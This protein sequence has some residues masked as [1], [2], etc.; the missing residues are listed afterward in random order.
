MSDT[1]DRINLAAEFETSGVP[2]VLKALD[3]WGDVTFNYASTDQL[4]Y[5]PTPTAA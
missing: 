5:V 1:P 3:V 2:E 4:D